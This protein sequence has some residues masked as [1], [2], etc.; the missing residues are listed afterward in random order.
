MP[1]RYDLALILDFLEGLSDHNN[2]PWFE[3]HRPAYEAARS[4]FFRFVDGLIDEFRLPDHLEGL[5]AK[6]C[7]ARIFRDIR[8]SKDK[9]PCNTSLSVMIAPGGWRST[10]FGY[11]VALGPRG[12]SMTAG[13]L[14]RPSPEQLARFRQTMDQDA[15]PFKKLIRAKA[16]VEAFGAVEGE[17]L[18]TA[19]PGFDRQHP[20][21]ELLQLKQVTAVHRFAD[22][23]VLGPEFFDRVVDVCQ[24]MK[25]FLVYL[26]HVAG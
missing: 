20:A 21:I 26:E 7:A 1:T 15:T 19:P 10:R 2:K 8:F 4:E 12:Q 11:Y 18:K 14:Y 17:R 9:S 25:P 24:A 23:D 22:R 5:T 16:F 6:S 3:G 13:G